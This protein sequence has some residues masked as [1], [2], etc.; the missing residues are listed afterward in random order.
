M[1]ALS[2]SRESPV[3]M[4]MTISSGEMWFGS[5]CTSTERLIAVY[6]TSPTP[7]CSSTR[8]R[9]RSGCSQCVRQPDAQPTGKFVLNRNRRLLVAVHRLCSMSCSSRR[10]EFSTTSTVVAL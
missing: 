2:C 10:R 3:A 1:P 4:R 6:L 7:A 5:Y 9:M 8:R